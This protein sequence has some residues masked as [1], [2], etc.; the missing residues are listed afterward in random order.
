MKVALALLTLGL[1]TLAGL[2]YA[3]ARWGDCALADL[4]GDRNGAPPWG[5]GHHRV[6][7]GRADG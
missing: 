6:A 5:T 2:S 1:A 7:T 4:D 3:L